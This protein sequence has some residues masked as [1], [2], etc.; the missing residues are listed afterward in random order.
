MIGIVSATRRGARL[1]AQLASRLPDAR[2]YRGSAREALIRAWP[3]CDG[4][5]AFLATGAVVRLCA[6][7]LEDKTKDPALVCVDEACRWTVAL[8][9][10]HRG[11]NELALRIG[12]LLG[13]TPVITTASEALGVEA[14]DSFGRD[15]GFAPDPQSD[16][17]AVGAALISGETVYF[18]SDQR[19]PL[20]PL[21][22]GVV[23][24][25]EPRAPCLLVTDRLVDP[26]RPAVVYR[27]PSLVCGVGASRGVKA[28]EVL[29]LIDSALEEAGLSAAS[30]AALA[31]IDVKADEAGLREAARLRGW[32]IRYRSAK[33]LSVIEVPS[34]S[35]VAEAAVGTPSVAEA[36]VL[37]EGAE[38]VVGKRRSAHA[39]VAVGRL[40]PKGRLYLVGAGPG[41]EDLISPQAREALARCEIVMGL[42]R[43]IEQIRPLLRPGV[44]IEASEIGEE[45]YRAQRAVQE[46]RRGRA[47]AL[48]SGG[49]AGVFGMASPALELAGPD[50]D[51]V[52]VP[53]VTAAQAAAAVLG[54]PLGH[55]HCSISLSD[56]HTPWEVI[57]RRIEAAAYADFVVVFY[58]PRSSRRLRQLEEALDIL[59]RHRPPSTPVGVVT[60][61]FRPGCRKEITTLA[62]IEV[63]AIGMT[64]TVI[65]GNSHTR[66]ISGRMVTPRAYG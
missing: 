32:P 35:P 63:S 46:A 13:A 62:D 8:L 54:A 40:R 2:L 27:P 51:V 18:S 21:P 50:I 49:D 26:P 5:V 23:R 39:T 4:I 17:A 43:Y 1:G 60:D 36:S 48:I 20:P 44:I 33:E 6:P 12:Q 61:A 24:S 37:A 42:R 7:L 58:N 55:D 52:S 15:L 34:P 53:G 19:R 29:E 66:V 3:E 64:T 57:R 9:G 14:L 47:V 41:E 22:E 30:V 59:R 38:L 28:D 65:V 11:A 56:L 25:P 16:L 10:G 45:S 31:T